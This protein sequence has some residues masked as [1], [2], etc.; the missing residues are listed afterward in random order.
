MCLS[1]DRD[2]QPWKVD[3]SWK[4]EPHS[5]ISM[6]S[7]NTFFKMGGFSYFVLCYKAITHLFRNLWLGNYQ[8]AKIRIWYKARLMLKISKGQKKQCKRNPIKPVSVSFYFPFQDKTYT[9]LR[10]LRFYSIWKDKWYTSRKASISLHFQAAAPP[11]QAQ[12]QPRF[13]AGRGV[14]RNR[15]NAAWVTRN[16]L[17]RKS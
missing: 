2:V 10:K 13:T 17:S 11:S 16:R 15:A 6:R 7:W 4:S 1:M 9:L 14:T 3:G 5:C 12:P 8:R